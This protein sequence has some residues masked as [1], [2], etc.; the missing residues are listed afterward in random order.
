MV[1][2]NQF[3]INK[4]SQNIENQTTKKT[5]ISKLESLSL[6]L[7]KPIYDILKNPILYYP[8]IDQM[9]ESDATKKNFI[10]MIMAVFKN[11]DDLNKKKQTA[12]KEWK[13]IHEDLREKEEKRY[14]KNKPNARQLENYIS[15]EEIEAKYNELLKSDPHKSK[16]C[17]Q[18]YVLLSLTLN[19]R[20][21]RADFGNI[22]IV[23]NE[24]IESL[25][26]NY[27]VIDKNT[28]SYLI[29]TEYK[30]AKKYET[31]KEALPESFYKDIRDSLKKYPRNFLF[32]DRNSNPYLE[33]KSYSS[34]VIR[35]FEKL[36][37]KKIGVTML[38]HIYIREK[39]DFNNMTQEELEDE[40]RLMTHSP[41]LQRLYRWIIREDELKTN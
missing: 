22:S 9:I 13:K 24:R 28:N 12:H 23:S 11:I 18:E 37:N 29:L 6:K 27:M 34:F 15:F 17:S 40:A 26:N 25:T 4:L 33:K 1:L 7:Q 5:Y 35:T 2:T 36:F 30:T 19:I 3:I 20:P 14:K 31:I 32:T 16:L 38:R 41:E 39:L 8:K 10:T 21:K